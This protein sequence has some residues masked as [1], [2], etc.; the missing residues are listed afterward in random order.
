MKLAPMVARAD[1]T[2]GRRSRTGGLWLSVIRGNP[3]NAAA[4]LG[5]V[6]DDL[7]WLSRAD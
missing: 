2:R 7:V 6:S 1:E 3:A 4:G 5:A